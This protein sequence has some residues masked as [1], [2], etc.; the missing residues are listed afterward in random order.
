[1]DLL[2]DKENGILQ[3]NVQ[4]LHVGPP[5]TAQDIGDDIVVDANVA[6]VNS[7]LKLAPDGHTV[8]V[9]QPSDDPNDPL[10]WSPAKKHALLVV[11]SVTAGLGDYSSAAGIPLIV[12]QG[13]EWS[14]S[15]AKVNETGN[16]NVLMVY[17]MTI[18]E[19]VALTQAVLSVVSSGLLSLPGGV[20]HPSSSGL[21]LP[22]LPSPSLVLLLATT[23][24]TMASA[25]SW[26]SAYAPSK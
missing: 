6:G 3:A 26:A 19:T 21:P 20:A 9:P 14:K 17:V 25:S 18:S 10:N 2:V 7:N 15:P 4:I 5:R 24:S 23:P 12:A 22:E 1:M 16:L 13:L 8:L 11:L